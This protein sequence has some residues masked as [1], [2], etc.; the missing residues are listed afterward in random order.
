MGKFR[1]ASFLHVFAVKTY[2]PMK[3]KEKVANFLVIKKCDKRTPTRKTNTGNTLK[4]ISLFMATQ[5]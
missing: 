3:G 5:Q 2:P 1:P 4:E